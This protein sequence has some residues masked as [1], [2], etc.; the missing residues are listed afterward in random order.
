MP[1]VVDGVRLVVEGERQFNKAIKD[2]WGNLDKFGESVVDTVKNSERLQR[3]MKKTQGIVGKFGKLVSN[4]FSNIKDTIKGMNLDFGRF[5][6]NIG[7]L[8]EQFGGFAKL[9]AGIPPPALAAAGAIGLLVAGTVALGLRGAALEPIRES[10][11][12][13]TQSIQTTSEALLGDMREAAQ[14]TISDFELMRLAN[15]ALTGATG[16]VGLAF[17]EALPEFINIARAAAAATGDSVDQ[18][19]QDIVTGVKRGSAPILDNLGIIVD[20][21]AA[22][23]AYAESINTTVEALTEE[24]KQIAFINGVM[25]AGQ[26]NTESFGNVQESAADKIDRLN[27]TIANMLDYLS[28]AVQPLFKVILDVVNQVVGAFSAF[29]QFITPAIQFLAEFVAAAIS[30][31]V[32]VANFFGNLFIKPIIGFI[33]NSLR[34]L[35]GFARELAIA[36]A[37]LMGTFANAMIEAAN[38]LILPALI[39]ITDLIADFLVGQSPPPKGALSKI[40]KGGAAT[41]SAWLQGFTGTSL[42]PINQV[43]REVSSLM[44]DA[45][46]LSLSQVETRLGQLDKQIAPFQ[47]RLRLIKANFDA[48]NEP[49]KNAI[50][51]LDRQ[52]QKA[53]EAVQ[54]GVEGSGEALRALRAQQASIG[55]VL[56]KE[57]AR[58]DAAQLQ[59][60]FAKAAQ[61]NERTALEIRR[62]QL[63]VTEKTTKE[64]KKLAKAA[65]KKSAQAKAPTGGGAAANAGAAI[66]T[67]NIGLDAE[68]TEEQLTPFQE[69]VGDLGAAFEGAIDPSALAEFEG[70]RSALDENL[71]RLEGADVTGRFGDIFGGIV[72]GF[73]EHV[74]DPME[75]HID[76]VI[77]WFTDTNTEGTLAHGLN[78]LGSNVSQWFSNVGNDFQVWLEDPI[79]V[80]VDNIVG[81]FNLGSVL[82]LGLSGLGGN[83]VVWLNSIPDDLLT[84]LETPFSD[85]ITRILNMFGLGE[86]G[87]GLSIQNLGGNLLTWVT[88]GT[89]GL[90]ESIGLAIETPFLTAL[91]NIVNQFIGTQTVGTLA[92]E[93]LQLPI[94]LGF[95][96]LD[97]PITL[98]DTLLSPFETTVGDVIRKIVGLDDEGSLAFALNAFFFGSEEGSLAFFL[99]E[100]VARLVTFATESVPASLAQFGIGVWN[101]TA[102]P[103]IEVLNYMIDRINDFLTS[104]E[105]GMNGVTGFLNSIGIQAPT[106]DVAIPRI[107]TDP[108]SFLTNLTQMRLGGVTRGFF[109]AGEEGTERMFA[110]DNTTVVP[111]RLSTMFGHLES[112]IAPVLSQVMPHGTNISNV[113]GD[114]DNSRNINATINNGRIDERNLRTQLALINLGFG[115]S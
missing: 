54:Q 88:E 40:D 82:N 65:P 22:Q 50:S 37:T 85:T 64:V 62:D 113:S 42:E 4:A 26:A 99:S 97:L 41:M 59:L 18:A 93:L 45:A 8:S 103:F 11:D 74:I 83:L 106:F 27:A 89:T 71:A 28:V 80:T 24:Q 96:L 55:G 90:A 102:V 44:G 25:A 75:E 32:K 43:T 100:A 61:V 87:L 35:G 70:N 109:Q 6:V 34:V 84:A 51:A 67:S 5:E 76:T 13:L 108:P 110:A 98:I 91:G 9:L 20:V 7:S 112:I 52:I 19:F 47:N 107:S 79:G 68:Q 31:L 95:W 92:Y 1:L 39:F 2:A 73:T 38:T 60:A 21:Q 53:S 111:H 72:D 63:K 14:G 94:S 66:D 23:E 3:A 16:D 12:G 17:G 49:A 104:V 77:G 30:S 101:M 46:T 58:V 86:G 105:N 81:M 69:F 115:E 114:T 33:Q 56:Q 48:I 10:F 78:N 29:V 57:Q 15:I 36:G